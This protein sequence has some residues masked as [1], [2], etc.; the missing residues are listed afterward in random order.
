VSREEVAAV[1]KALA[2]AN[3]HSH[4]DDYAEA[5]AN[6]YVEPGDV[7]EAKREESSKREEA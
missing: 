5:V 6:A 3:G 7:A 1:A 2:I 4:P